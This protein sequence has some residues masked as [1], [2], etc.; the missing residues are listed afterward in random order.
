MKITKE[1][2]GTCV[3]YGPP[4]DAVVDRITGV[5]DDHGGYVC[6]EARD[7]YSDML[8]GSMFRTIEQITQH[9]RPA[10]EEETNLFLLR[11]TPPPQNWD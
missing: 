7:G 5:G 6:I 3:A 11:Y 2:I 1:H 10:T 8:T 9:W 4:S